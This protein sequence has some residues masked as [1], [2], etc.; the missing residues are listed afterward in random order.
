ME[1][2]LILIEVITLINRF[3]IVICEEINDIECEIELIGVLSNKLVEFLF[4]PKE[5]F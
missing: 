3:C 4:F 5:I 2:I 1:N